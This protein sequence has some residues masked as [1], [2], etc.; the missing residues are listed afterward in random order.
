M[1]DALAGR[2]IVLGL[3]NLEQIRDVARPVTSLLEG[4]PGLRILA[5]S[6]VPLRIRGEV[7]VAVKTLELPGA[8]TMAGLEA[9]AAGSLFLT[10]ARAIGRLRSIDD[11][12]ASD[13]RDLLIR[14][15]G[16]PLAIELAAARTRAMSPGEIVDRLD[17]LGTDAID[18]LDGSRQRSLRAILGWT[19]GL[20][21]PAHLALLEA[22]SIC[23]GF[24][25][26]LAQSLAPTTDV[27][28]AVE[29]LVALGLVLHAGTVDGV[30]RFRLLETIRSE[31]QKRLSDRQTQTFRDRHAE[32]FLELAADWYQSAPGGLR[33]GVLERMDTDADNIRRA[34]DH[35]DAVDPRRALVLWLHLEPFW[36]SR[37]RL[38]EGLDRFRRTERL[39]P[40]PSAELAR[41][42][43]G[44]LTLLTGA[45]GPSHL[46]PLIPE[47]MAIAE[48]ARDQSALIDVLATRMW[49]AANEGDPAVV[50]G[51]ELDLG[52]IDISDLD[53]RGRINLLELRVDAAAAREGFDSDA[54]RI[55]HARPPRRGT[56]RRLDDLPCRISLQSRP[57]SP[58]ARRARRSRTIGWRGSGYPAP[59]RT[60]CASRLGAEL[61]VSRTR[62]VGAHDEAMRAIQE[63]ARIADSLRLDPNVRDALLNAM[64]LAV[65]IGELARSRTLLGGGGAHHRRG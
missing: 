37:G 59:G 32:A 1:I 54:V 27:V 53:A 14:L 57:G 12:T 52:A 7:E 34:L 9:S 49:I 8:A 16:L 55:T 3:D 40:E 5:T 31:I 65:A 62:G 36:H 19:V 47:V 60:D 39:A 23:A 21:A 11:A 58:W 28:D 17:R 64:P 22:V 45:F 13:V 26:G 38:A 61:P 6:R 35:L 25:L 50:A 41:A 30:S 29:P 63:S 46:K 20:L 4:A 42:A 2:E 10:R 48:R 33:P 43:A 51:I 56:C 24:D 44:H 15:D 18:P